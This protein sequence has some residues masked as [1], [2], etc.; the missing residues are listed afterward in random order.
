M[1]CK[2]QSQVTVHQFVFK[3]SNYDFRKENLLIGYLDELLFKLKAILHK[4]IFF[5]QPDHDCWL[6]IDRYVIANSKWET[7]VETKDFWNIHFQ[8]LSYCLERINLIDLNH[9]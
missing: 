1:V 9:V 4:K 7:E 8:G 5:T 6:E 3:S 2:I